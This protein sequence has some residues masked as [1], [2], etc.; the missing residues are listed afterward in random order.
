MVRALFCLPCLKGTQRHSNAL[1][2]FNL[3]C[4]KKKSKDEEESD[5][6]KKG[7]RKRGWKRSRS[8]QKRSDNSMKQHVLAEETQRERFKSSNPRLLQGY[9]R[10]HGRPT[11]GERGLQDQIRYGQKSGRAEKIM[12]TSI[13]AHGGTY[14]PAISDSRAKLDTARVNY[15]ASEPRYLILKRLQA[16]TGWPEH[17]KTAAAKLLHQGPGLVEILNGDER[18]STCQSCARARKR[19]KKKKKN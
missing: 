14:L 10:E 8:K 19:K 4:K 9:E 7:C 11:K 1:I 17:L 18:C 5:I 6:Q 16:A 3:A 12:Q 13:E 2:L 15:F